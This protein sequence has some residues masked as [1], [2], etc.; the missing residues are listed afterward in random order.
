VP[1]SDGLI[2]RSRTESSAMLSWRGAAEGVDGFLMMLLRDGVRIA[3]RASSKTTFAQQLMKVDKRAHRNTRRADRH[4]GTGDR[5]QHPCGHHGDHARRHFD[6]NVPTGNALLAIVP[7]NTAPK[8]RV[9]A[10][11]NL[12]LLPD[13]GRMNG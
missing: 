12:D 4:A 3:R 5:I 13:M 6:V 8:E 9:P 2:P 10:V 7:A 11:M 1:R